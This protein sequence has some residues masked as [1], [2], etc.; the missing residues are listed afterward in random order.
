MLSST[1]LF[2]TPALRV[3]DVRCLHA[4]G[5]W[6]GI[7]AAPGSAVIFARRG[8]FRRRCRHGEQVVEP[9]VALLQHG[10]EEEEFAHPH[11]GG[12]DCTAV[13]VDDAL[14]AA[15]LGGDPALPSGVVAT[16]QRDD[17][18]HRS[19]VAAARGGEREQLLLAL[20]ELAA[21][22][23]DLLVVG[24]GAAAVAVH[25]DRLDE[26]RED[27][28]PERMA[29]AERAADRIRERWRVLEEFNL[30]AGLMLE[31]LFVELWQALGTTV[32]AAA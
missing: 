23:R 11:D 14:L 30:Q 20:E 6:S 26:L 5:P 3:Y 27:A 31:A 25:A 22:Y 18:A 16:S 8:A 19:I 32:P 10:G 28:A 24:A 15:L 9:G 2:D 13:R 1:A 12:D 21:W 17:L 7:E 29:G 4:R